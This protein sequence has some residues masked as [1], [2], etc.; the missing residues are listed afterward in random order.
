MPIP[1]NLKLRFGPYVTPRYTIGSVVMDEV[2]GEVTIVGTSAGRIPWP[3]GQTVR[4]RSLV[5][6]EG[7]ARA[8]RQEAGVAVCHHWG[9]TGQTVTKWRKAIGIVGQITRGTSAC[10]SEQLLGEKGQKMRAALLPVL[11]SPER[12]AKISA[13]KRG[14]PR[15]P[16]VMERLRQ[17]N[18]RRKPS[19]EA[20]ARMSAAQKAR[21]AWPP[22]AGK[23]WS[24]QEDVIILSLPTGEA[25][26]KTGRS[27]GAV[28]DRL[29]KLKSLAQIKLGPTNAQVR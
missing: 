29:R 24:K 17:S 2:R 6:Y 3:I 12:A 16:E 25:A 23:P 13:A 14:V 1:A 22:A 19:A 15:P 7:L 18:L 21:G 5:V 11:S 9:I 10:S 4:A 27:A 20:R 8:I 26:S 28:R